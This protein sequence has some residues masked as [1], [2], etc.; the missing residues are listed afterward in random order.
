MLLNLKHYISL[1]KLCS[2]KVRQTNIKTVYFILLEI[3]FCTFQWLKVVKSSIDKVPALWYL[4]F[5]N[6]DT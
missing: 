2:T 5:I 6:L 1:T 4:Q 3:P